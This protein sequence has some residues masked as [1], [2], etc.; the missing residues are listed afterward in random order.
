MAAVGRNAQAEQRL[1]MALDLFTAGEDAMRQR[2]RRQSPALSPQEIEARLVQWLQE[3]P[4]AEFGDSPGTPVA[5]P[6]PSR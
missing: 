2:L 4:G 1:R 6:R 5:W 3:R